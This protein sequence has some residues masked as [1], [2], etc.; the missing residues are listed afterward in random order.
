MAAVIHLWMELA[1][2]EHYLLATTL[3][4]VLV[5]GKVMD[6]LDRQNQQWIRQERQGVMMNSLLLWSEDRHWQIWGL[7]M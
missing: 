4:S 3:H 1:R 5:I 7:A 2:L 6:L